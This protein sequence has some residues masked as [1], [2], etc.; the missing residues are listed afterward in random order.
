[1]TTLLSNADGDSPADTQKA[2]HS[3]SHIADDE[4]CY[5]R[6]LQSPVYLTLRTS[7][8]KVT[9]F[10]CKPSPMVGTLTGRYVRRFCYSRWRLCKTYFCY[11]LQRLYSTNRPCGR[12]RAHNLRTCSPPIA[13]AVVTWIDSTSLHCPSIEVTMS[14]ILETASIIPVVRPTWTSYKNSDRHVSF[15]QTCLLIF[16]S[17]ITAT[18][19]TILILPHITLKAMI[20]A[21]IL[22]SR[23]PR[24]LSRSGLHPLAHTVP[25]IPMVCL[26]P[27]RLFTATHWCQYNIF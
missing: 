15:P 16:P 14:Q 3:A 12:D 6:A 5:G 26:I 8:S 27:V 23:S 24:S 7:I 11:S 25:C 10:L 1:M 4:V 9:F 13:R 18:A 22:R 2:S 17:C 19:T 20:L 21:I